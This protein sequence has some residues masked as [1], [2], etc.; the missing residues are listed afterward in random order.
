M[1][2]FKEIRDF[3][4]LSY[5]QKVNTTTLMQFIKHKLCRF[6]DK[7]RS[8]EKGFNLRGIIANN[9]CID[10]RHNDIAPSLI[11]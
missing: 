6:E 8:I 5:R 10:H 3:N 7:G 11:T 9:S 4:N 1:L 2:K